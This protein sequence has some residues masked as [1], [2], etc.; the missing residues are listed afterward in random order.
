MSGLG[1]TGILLSIRQQAATDRHTGWTKLED[2]LHR[3]SQ[4]HKHT[5]EEWGMITQGYGVS[6]GGDEN[7]LEVDRRC[8]TLR[9]N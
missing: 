3:R 2:M 5:L 1:G 7:V 6:F 8:I 9:T 4:T